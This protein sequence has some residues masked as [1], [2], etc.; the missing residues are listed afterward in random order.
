MSLNLTNS[1]DIICNS[2]K[3]IENG[4]LVDLDT[5]IASGSID[6][7]TIINDSTFRN[8]NTLNNYTLTADINTALALKTDQSYLMSNFM[9]T[10]DITASLSTLTTNFNNALALK[11]NDTDLT[12]TSNLVTTNIALISALQTTTNTHNRYK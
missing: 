2:L 1:I 7:N 12:T 9:L 3:I 6:V 5:K 10:T 11:A 8:L 4:Q